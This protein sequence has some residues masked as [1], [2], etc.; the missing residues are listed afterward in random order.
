MSQKKRGAV[1]AEWSKAFVSSAKQTPKGLVRIPAKEPL[2]RVIVVSPLATLTTACTAL[3]PRKDQ[4]PK[5]KIPVV[6]L[7]GSEPAGR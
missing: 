3:T 7:E 2:F 4:K 6:A 1:L 5:P